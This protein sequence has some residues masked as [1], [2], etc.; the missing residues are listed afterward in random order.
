[1]PADL[2][3]DT[4]GLASRLEGRSR[5]WLLDLPGVQGAPGPWLDTVSMGNPHAMQIVTDVD[6]APVTTEGPA[7]ERHRR[8]PRPGQR[9]LLPD[10]FAKRD[11]IARLRARRRRNLVLW[12]RRLRCR[13]ERHTAGMA[14]QQRSGPHPGRSPYH[15]LGREPRI[16]SRDDRAGRNRVPGERMGARSSS[17][18]TAVRREDPI[19]GQ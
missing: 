7:I 12:H 19:G 15:F 5:L 14:R 9:R 8:F 16:D 18:I 4:A 13:G 11:P 1:M 17:P 10:R 6:A 2:P 3:F